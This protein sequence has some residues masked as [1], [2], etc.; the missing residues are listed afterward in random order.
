MA[1][2]DE[3]EA[4]QPG[5]AKDQQP[6]AEIADRVAADPAERHQ[7]PDSGGPEPLSVG[8]VDSREQGERREHRP[9]EGIEP[10]ERDHGPRLPSLRSNRTRREA[11]MMNAAMA[12][13]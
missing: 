7:A 1:T 9:G 3:A 4:G 8:P 13:G 12:V 10:V 5:E 11:W 2:A 6:V